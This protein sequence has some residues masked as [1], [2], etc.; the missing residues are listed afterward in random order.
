MH[1]FQFS[2]IE[3]RTLFGLSGIYALRMLGLFLL[4]PVFSL[5]ANALVNGQNAMLA[6]LALGAY[7]LAQAVLH[8]PMGM[9][10]DRFGRKTIILIGLLL[11]AIGALICSFAN[12]IEWLIIGRLIQGSGAISAAITALLADLTQE[13]HRTASMAVIGITIAL[14]FAIAIVAA[15]FL[16]SGIGMQ[17]IFLFM[18]ITALLA[19]P[20][21]YTVIP[22]P[23][24]SPFHADTETNFST[25]RTVFSI[26]ELWRLNFGILTLH[27]SQMALFYVLPF[28]LK[29]R[30]QLDIQAHTWIYLGAALLS[31]IV[32]VP[33]IAIAESKDRL[34]PFFTGSVM[35]IAL[36]FALLAEPLQLLWVC[37]GLF[38]FLAAFNI[39]EAS[40]PSLVSKI[41]PVSAKG[42]AIGIYATSQSIGIFLGA[43]IAGF[44]HA[45]FGLSAVYLCF[46]VWALLWFFITLSMKKPPAVRTCLYGIGNLSRETAQTLTKELS[47]VK[48]VY[49]AIILS[50]DGVAM[51][52]VDRHHFNETEVKQLIED[53]THG[54][55]G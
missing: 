1:A 49:E 24:R 54:S 15:P 20:I 31:F 21:L 34:K 19:I 33:C 9:L 43:M 51:L 27:A 28:E 35:V 41:A 50:E 37:L 23:I 52:K 3:K 17:G 53:Y 47:K 5:Y 42:S 7:P 32:M 13:E 39:L 6:G 4:Y 46:T 14:S 18:A 36:S 48:G 22:N 40:L 10:S 12:T 38:L 25:L 8:I 11:L 55:I 2:S 16:Y 26:K 44:L 45:H 29:N 30:F